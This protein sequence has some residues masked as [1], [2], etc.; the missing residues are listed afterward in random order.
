MTASKLTKKKIDKQNML[1][2]K[3][4]E[5]KRQVTYS[6]W[7]SPKAALLTAFYSYIAIL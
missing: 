7:N 6:G 4:V 3:V 2:G 1:H 5:Y